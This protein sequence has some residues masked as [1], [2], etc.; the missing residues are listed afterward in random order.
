[1]YI[2]Q[3][4]IKKFIIIYCLT[5]KSKNANIFQKMDY[6][7]MEISYQKVI[8]IRED[9]VLEKILNIE[10]DVNCRLILNI[11]EDINMKT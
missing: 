11:K 9:R 2:I 1:M 7:K 4:Y 6:K 10:L 3:T 8:Q 5:K